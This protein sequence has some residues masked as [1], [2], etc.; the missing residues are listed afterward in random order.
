M[1][2]YLIVKISKHIDLI[3]QMYLF[4]I[5]LNHMFISYKIKFAMN[6]S[7]YQ[8]G[9]Q[10]QVGWRFEQSGLV[11]GIPVHVRGVGTR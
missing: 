4:N 3:V 6:I 5:T 9:N 7:S 2:Y 10:S 11:G 8:K 1:E